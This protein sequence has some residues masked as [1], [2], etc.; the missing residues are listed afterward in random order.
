MKGFIYLLI[1]L[2]IGAVG[3][4]MVGQKVDEWRVARS[5]EKHDSAPTEDVA[6]I[7]QEMLAH[8]KAA[9]QN[10]DADQLLNDCIS[11][12][13]EINGNSGESMDLARAR[14]YYHNYFRGGQAI[15]FALENLQVNNAP[16]AIIAQATFKKTSNAFSE[17]SIQGYK[18]HGTW[19]F[20][21][22]NSIWQLAS[23]VW[24]EEAY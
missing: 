18:G 9:Y 14:V 1:I 20:V 7:A 5:T 22:Q 21:R 6:A 24:T 2:L 8:E 3:G 15:N 16:N 4:Y 12:Y 11:S 23:V 19:V 13:T 17:K 10:H